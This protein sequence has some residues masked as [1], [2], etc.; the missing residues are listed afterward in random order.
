[1][2]FALLLSPVP[3]TSNGH[4]FPAFLYGK[5][6]LLPKQNEVNKGSFYHWCLPFQSRVDFNRRVQLY[7]WYISQ[8]FV[9][10]QE[11]VPP[12]RIVVK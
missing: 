10:P 7:D 3:L 2:D 4:M 12:S 6:T 1:M 5:N 11:C 9:V 8:I